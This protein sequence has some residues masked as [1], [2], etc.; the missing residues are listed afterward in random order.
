MHGIAY[1]LMPTDGDIRIDV[2]NNVLNPIP[3]HF[4]EVHDLKTRVNRVW[5][6]FNDGDSQ[7]F[8][9]DPRLYLVTGFLRITVFAGVRAEPRHFSQKQLEDACSDYIKVVIPDKDAAKRRFFY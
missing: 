9:C 5:L 8:N 1:R 2:S 6:F 7:T 3:G 4:S